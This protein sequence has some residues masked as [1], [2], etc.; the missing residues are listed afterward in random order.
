[1]SIPQSVKACLWSYDIDQ[2]D[3]ATHK[4]LIIGNVL[5]YGTKAATDWLFD[6]YP[7][8]DIAA[9]AA[10]FPEGFWTAK[11]LALWSLVL[12][13]RPEKRTARFL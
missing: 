6:Q 4:Q 2:I 8:S 11:S 12:N 7:K 3:L 9:A 13:F 5:N 1:M 10:S